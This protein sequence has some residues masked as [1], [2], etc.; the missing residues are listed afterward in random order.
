ME[1]IKG[2]IKVEWVEF[3]EGLHGDYDPEDPATMTP[4]RATVLNAPTKA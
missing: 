2:N 4:A 3:G 1:L